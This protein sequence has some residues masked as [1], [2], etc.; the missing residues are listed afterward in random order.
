MGV[1]RFW[2]KKPNGGPAA[3]S[4]LD[5]VLLAVRSNI[6]E[7]RTQVRATYPYADAM[8]GLPTVSYNGKLLRVSDMSV[9]GM[10]LL[11]PQLPT[12]SLGAIFDFQISFGT[13][14]RAQILQQGEVIR[15]EQDRWHIRFIKVESLFVV[16][17][18]HATKFAQRGSGT[19]L[20]DEKQLPPD[21][22]ISE[23]WMS[24]TGEFI[25]FQSFTAPEENKDFDL[26]ATE[27][28]TI[29]LGGN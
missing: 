18:T 27:I 5:S 28:V 9:G 13:S 24:A 3:P 21:Q 17:F 14:S 8:G 29:S 25:M 11:A 20:L 16:K 26:Q 4:D 12:Q 6:L 23:F 7:R 1:L 19:R 2:K 10:L 15:V 22:N